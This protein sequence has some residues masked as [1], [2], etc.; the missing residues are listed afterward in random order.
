MSLEQIFASLKLDEASSVVDP[1]KSQGVEKSG[2]AA[3]ASV[4]A[5]RCAS[6]DESEA[7]AAMATVKALA[8]SVPEAQVF[9][10]MCLAA[11][12][13]NSVYL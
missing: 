3:N 2:L 10:K 12:K 6:K 5:A 8:E 11:C 9:T 7:L 13:Y 1:V 4:L